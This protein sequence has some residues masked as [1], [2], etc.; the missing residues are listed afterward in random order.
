MKRFYLQL[1]MMLIV[2][3]FASCSPPAPASI[4]TNTAAT[5]P[6]DE[7]Q[8]GEQATATR[9]GAAT[10]LPT[11]SPAVAATTPTHPPASATPTPIP[12]LAIEET[13]A[14]VCQGPPQQFY[15]AATL[16]FQWMAGLRF[17]SEE[18][19]TFE[20]WT[21]RPEP[22]I[23]PRTPEP[24][25]EP[26][27][28]PLSGSSFRIMLAGG[29]LDLSNGQPGPRPLDV[30]AP[31]ANPCGE[32]CPLEVL[33][34]SP[35]EQWQLAQI[36]DWLRAQMGIWL[37]SAETAIRIIPYVPANLRWQWAEDSSTLWLTYSFHDIGGE[38]LVIQLDNPPVVHASDPGGLL[39]PNLY[40][41]GYSPADNTA[42][43]VPAPMI[44]HENTDQ[45]FTID[46]GDDPERASGVWDLP[47]VKSV[48]WNEAT[49]SIT[50]QAVTEAGIL[51][52]ELTGGFSLIIPNETLASLLPSFTGA[53]NDLPT[54]LSAAGDWAISPSGSKLALFHSPSVMWFFDCVPAPS[55]QG[56]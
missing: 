47:G 54:G 18:R 37:L 29:Q 26:G 4:A 36:N 50:V 31:L 11:Q 48:A 32:V 20:G 8:A 42:F 38:T 51:F 13:V 53:A 21:H 55:H 41:S 22:S 40:W 30:D 19:L 15:L 3:A 44:G 34:Q 12:T 16:G 9:P 45:V 10:S 23:L 27:S 56:E 17:E 52:Q 7:P 2:A 43:A 6:N 25:P 5:L 24:T 39:D 1:A 35:D 33:G 49:R 28:L 46:L 14:M